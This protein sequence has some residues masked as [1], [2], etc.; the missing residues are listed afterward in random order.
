MAP[1]MDEQ[2][3][4]PEEPN[5]PRAHF[6][7]TLALLFIPFALNIG[8]WI[9]AITDVL[10][11]YSNRAQLVW[12]R[13][14]VALVVADAL[15]LGAFLWAKD[16]ADELPSTAAVHRERIGV[17]FERGD[18]PK[19]RAVLPGSPADHAGLRP[20]D[21][22]EKVDG[23]AVATTK[24]LLENSFSPGVEKVLSVRRGES[25]LE[26][27]VT[28]ARLPRLGERGL[29]ERE[30]LPESGSLEDVILELLPAALLV[31]ILAAWGR[32]RSGQALPVWGG[33]LLALVGGMG[34]A[35]GLL[36][37][38]KSWTGG[39]SLGLFLIFLVGQSLLMLGLTLA[40]RRWLGGRLLPE[41]PRMS[42]LRAG[43][44]GFFYLATGV[45]RLLFLVVVAVRLFFP[46]AALSDPLADLLSEAS[47]GR[48]G[49]ALLILGIAVAAPVAE[50]ALFRG[51][52]LPRLV[53]TWGE[54][55]A[56]TATSL[57]FALL[58]LRDGPLIP[59]IFAYGWIFGWVRLRS[60][61]VTASTVLHMTVNAVGVAGILMKS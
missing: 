46:D 16:H 57:L 29:F 48:L 21:L 52:L 43:L 45:P 24:A 23:A 59:V 4:A 37:L 50:E 25:S 44:Q 30:P 2:S 14:L 47:F 19:I 15:L 11:G 26:L 58:H 31:A 6:H 5:L 22:I 33:F 13:L 40:A 49:A 35:V 55:P 53:P 61:G 54:L 32:W 27:R 51:Y 34:G 56:L 8:G 3:R 36:A 18:V 38:A 17:D 10:K 12:T 42:P 28:P 20:G 39:M 7:L 60:G 41:S 1:R 9:M